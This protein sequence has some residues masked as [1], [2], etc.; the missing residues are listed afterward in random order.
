M[1]PLCRFPHFVAG[2]SLM[3][4]S[5]AACA[6]T[7]EAPKTTAAK[8][9]AAA[10]AHPPAAA[11]KPTWVTGQV[12]STKTRM[13]VGVRYAMT[14]PS[15]G[16]VGVLNLKLTR[17]GQGDPVSIEL[18]PDPEIRME[19]GFPTGPVALNAGDDYSITIR[20]ESEGL[21]YIHVYLQSGQRAEAMAIPV[22]VGKGTAVMAKPG[23][24]STMPDGQR[25]MSLPAQQ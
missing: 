24:L 2:A 20:P 5:V 6:G 7:A 14:E 18:R 16:S 19:S 25:V 8:P 10:T 21:H 23:M 11:R 12:R 9:G 13:G 1:N 17:L 22:Q 15:V 3:C 4:L